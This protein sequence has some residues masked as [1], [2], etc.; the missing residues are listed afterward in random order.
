MKLTVWTYEGPPH[1]GA[2]RVATGMRGL[3]YVLHAPQG[4]TYAD[5]LFTMIERRDRRPP[6]TYTT[7]QARDLGADTANLFKTACLEAVE[8]FDPQ[9]DHAELLTIRLG[10]RAGC[11]GRPAGRVG[12]VDEVDVLSVLP[13]ASDELV[14]EARLA[15]ARLALDQE[16]LAIALLCL[17]V[18][19]VELGEIVVPAVEG[20]LTEDADPAQ[21]ALRL[22]T[23]RLLALRPPRASLAFLEDGGQGGCVGEAFLA[24]LLQ[25]CVYDLLE[26]RRELR[27][28]LT[29]RPRDVVQDVPKH[30]GGILVPVRMLSSRKLVEDDTECVEVGSPVGLAFRRSK[31][32]RGGVLERPDERARL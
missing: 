26:E 27:I 12:P 4:D 25:E 22:E 29:S 6:V 19:S 13:K 24:V 8:R 10:E 31:L 11:R 16:D 18:Q 32:L 1:V 30:L 28:E 9:A 3:H 23:E 17:A 5:L 21:G 15:D 7:F 14:H 2:M 20:R